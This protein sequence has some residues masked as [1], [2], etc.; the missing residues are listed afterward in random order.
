M[1]MA[2]TAGEADHHS[3]A[4]AGLKHWQEKHCTFSAILFRSHFTERSFDSVG[5][6]LF[7]PSVLY[8]EIRS[9][10]I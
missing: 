9:G 4:A 7:R 2:G 10:L 8:F 6:G 1:P 3:W 5:T